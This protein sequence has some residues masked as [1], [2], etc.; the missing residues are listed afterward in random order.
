VEAICYAAGLLNINFKN[1]LTGTIASHVAIGL[2]FYFFTNNL[3][4]GKNFIISFLIAIAFIPWLLIARKRYLEEMSP[5][6][7]SN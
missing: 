7:T 6:S 1:Y 2:P 3:F 5:N 4:E